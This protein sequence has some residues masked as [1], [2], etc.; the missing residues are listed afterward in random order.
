MRGRGKSREV[1]GE[2]KKMEKKIV[3]T[4]GKFAIIIQ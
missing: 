4:I 3:P 2:G 1:E